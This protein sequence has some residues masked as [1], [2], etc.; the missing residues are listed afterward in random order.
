MGT[1]DKDRNHS[2]RW[3]QE[4]MVWMVI[5][6][7]F[8]AVIVGGFI[9]TM[10]IRSYDGLVVDDYYKQGKEINRVLHRSKVAS[11]SNITAS[12]DFQRSQNTVVVSLQHDPQFSPPEQL[13]FKLIH[14]TRSGLDQEVLLQRD[15]DGL[16][17]GKLTYPQLGIWRVQ[18]ETSEWRI[19]GAVTL[20]GSEQ[21]QSEQIMLRA[22]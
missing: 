14:R 21:I 3:Y 17:K 12:L 19:A 2:R 6:I 22:L 13:Q 7:P 1:A 4:P 10:A 8:S 20:S 5:A 9:L 15:A 18:L 11:Q 16:Y